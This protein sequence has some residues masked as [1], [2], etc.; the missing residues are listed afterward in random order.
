MFFFLF[1]KYTQ[2]DWV[3]KDNMASS[4]VTPNNTK[5]ED[6]RRYN[7]LQKLNAHLEF[8]KSLAAWEKQAVCIIHYRRS[9]AILQILAFIDP[10]IVIQ[11]AVHTI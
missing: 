4:H 9:S 1:F 8:K 3:A 10:F 5:F 6:M 7:C 2:S 11:K